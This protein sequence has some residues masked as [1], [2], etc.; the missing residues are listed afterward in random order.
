MDITDYTSYAEVRTTV[1]LS[2][3]ELSDAT[4]ASEIYAN[5][6]ELSMSEVSLSSSAPG[7]GLLPERFAAIAALTTRT[8]DEQKLYNL[9]RLFC[10]YAVAYEVATSLGMRTP[11]S[12]SDGKRTLVR[13][14]P[15]S[16]YKDTIDMIREKL[17]D[18]RSRLEKL[19]TALITSM[20]YMTVVS[21]GT[22]PITG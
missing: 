19:G 5:A 6:L 18:F 4:L 16:T 14:S 17:E 8:A 20:P 11:K 13:F 9:T 1:G 22:D 7:T 21:Q 15:E 3:D 12:E 2:I 10:T